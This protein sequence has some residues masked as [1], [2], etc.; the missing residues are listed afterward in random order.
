MQVQGEINA[1]GGQFKRIERGVVVVTAAVVG[2]LVGDGRP[3]VVF[4]LV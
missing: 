1:A 3:L 4:G 2:A